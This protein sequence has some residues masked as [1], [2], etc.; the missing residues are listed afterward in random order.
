VQAGDYFAVWCGSGSSVAIVG[1]GTIKYGA[2]GSAPTAGGTFTVGSTSSSRF[3]VTLN[4]L[5]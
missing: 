4:G 3:S 5:A 2:S 1:S